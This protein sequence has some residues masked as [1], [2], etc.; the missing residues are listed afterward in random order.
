MI[1]LGDR[2]KSVRYNLEGTVQDI[3]PCTHRPRNGVGACTE[4][5]LTLDPPG[6]GVTRFYHHASNFEVVGGD[7]SERV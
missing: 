1:Q 6:A 7:S 5:E 2:V 3:G 4:S